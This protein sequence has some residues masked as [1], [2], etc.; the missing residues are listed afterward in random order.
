MLKRIHAVVINGDA[1][2]QVRKFLG[3]HAVELPLGVN[4]DIFK[5]GSTQVRERIGWTENN[6]V[7][8][9]VGRLAYIKGVDILAEAFKD[10]RKTVP[11]ARLLIVG[12][13]EEEEKL[14]SRLRPELA[15]GFAHLEAG[16]PHEYLA[17]WYR[18]MDLFVMPS[19]YENLSNAVLEAMACG[20]SFL[21]SDI[22]GNRTYV[23]AEGGWLFT[24]GSVGSLAER[25][26]FLAENSCLARDRR[27]TIADKI[28]R[29][30]SWTATA[31]RLEDILQSC[32][33]KK[34]GVSCTP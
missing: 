21:G 8:G 25:L 29:D 16:V 4:A 11:H 24:P 31:K 18:A 17:E 28:C 2:N 30:H 13:G 5:P 32:L 9:Y 7:I 15:E 6:W 33:D 26:C 27:T 34:F 23:E 10:T 22:G 12:S 20:V 3:D 14:R 19:R 1:L